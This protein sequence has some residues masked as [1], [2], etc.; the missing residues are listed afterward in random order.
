MGL[1]VCFFLPSL[2]QQYQ[3]PEEWETWEEEAEAEAEG[4]W[5]VFM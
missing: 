3:Y 1:F 5:H 4:V 2:V